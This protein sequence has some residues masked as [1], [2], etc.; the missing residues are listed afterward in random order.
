[1][2]KKT[3]AVA[4]FLRQ[5]K[6]EQGKATVTDKDRTGLSKTSNST[7]KS[8]SSTPQKNKIRVM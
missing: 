7:N 8:A 2:S 6:I 5:K 4:E 1:M 3:R